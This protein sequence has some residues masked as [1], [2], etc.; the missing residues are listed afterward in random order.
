MLKTPATMESEQQCV[1]CQQES[2]SYTERWQRKIHLSDVEICLEQCKKKNL[3]T[4]AKNVSLR[5][6]L[7]FIKGPF[8][9][10]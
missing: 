1:C 3:K 9:S 8:F 6:K 2:E 5:A 10:T 4:M 7:Y